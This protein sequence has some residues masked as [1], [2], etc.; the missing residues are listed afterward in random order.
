MSEYFLGKLGG[1]FNVFISIY[2][3]CHVLERLT[4]WLYMERMKRREDPEGGTP[5]RKL[6]QAPCGL[7]IINYDTP[8]PPNLSPFNTPHQV[9]SA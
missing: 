4:E 3:E 8:L 6:C 5:I 2:H 1:L 9:Y 7:N